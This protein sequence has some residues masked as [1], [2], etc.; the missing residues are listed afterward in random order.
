MSGPKTPINGGHPS[1]LNPVDLARS[2]LRTDLQEALD[3]EVRPALRQLQ[4]FVHQLEFS[5]ETSDRKLEC[6]I[7]ATARMGVRAGAAASADVMRK[8]LKAIEDDRAEEF[9]I[10]HLPC[11]VFIHNQHGEPGVIGA[12]DERAAPVTVHVLASPRMGLDHINRQMF[13][14]K[15]KGDAL[16]KAKR[17]VESAALEAQ[18]VSRLTSPP[19][20]V[21][22][23]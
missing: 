7:D 2:I 13:T 22:T 16:R 19:M 11:E 14:G 1:N 5:Q 20:K 17:F 21:V 9:R 23:P 8:K 3:A 4:E 15:D 12:Y 18:K 6:L 10:L